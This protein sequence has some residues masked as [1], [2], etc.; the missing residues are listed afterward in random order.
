VLITKIGSV[1]NWLTPVDSV[2]SDISDQVGY[3]QSRADISGLQSGSRAVALVLG[4]IYLTQGKHIRCIGH[5][6]PS[7]GLQ[8]HGSRVR[9]D[10]SY[11]QQI[12]PTRPKSAESDLY[13]IW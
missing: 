3:I 7:V 5:I 4:W 1:R 9:S 8:S 10:I 13:I 2:A 6:R 11:L 12:Y